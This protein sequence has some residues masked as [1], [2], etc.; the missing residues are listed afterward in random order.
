MG[1]HESLAAYPLCDVPLAEIYCH[2]LK[3]PA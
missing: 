1:T 2:L 3:F